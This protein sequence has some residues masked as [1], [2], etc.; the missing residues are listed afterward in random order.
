ME[1]TIVP[2]EQMLTK[3]QVQNPQTKWQMLGSHKWCF[4]FGL[5]KTMIKELGERSGN[6]YFTDKSHKPL[7]DLIL[8]IGDDNAEIIARHYEFEH[9]EYFREFISWVYNWVAPGNG[10][11]CPTGTHSPKGQHYNQMDFFPYKTLFDLYKKEVIE[12]VLE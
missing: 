12:P 9:P 5:R 6:Y 1:N 4:D 11:K 3:Q 7:W 10:Y 8:Y 2:K